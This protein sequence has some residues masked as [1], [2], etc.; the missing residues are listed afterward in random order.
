MWCFICGRTTDGGGALEDR[1]T[2]I[3]VIGSG[4]SGFAAALTAA[5][6]GATVVVFEK[7]SFYG[8]TSRFL[9]GM[10]AVESEM[11]RQRYIGYSRD[12]AFKNLMDYSHWRAD[13]RIVRAFVDESGPTI[14]WLE[15]QGVV[16][17]DATINLLDGLRTYHTIAGGGVMLMKTLAARSKERGVELLLSV[18]VRGIAREVDGTFSITAEKKGVMIR[19]VARA[20]IIA[21][22]GYGSNKEWI[23]RYTGL[24]LGVNLIPIGQFSKMGDGIRI[25][26]ESG[27]GTEG[28]GILLGFRVGPMG[29]GSI[30]GGTL[31]T[32]VVQPH[33]WINPRGERFCNETL[34]FSDPVMGNVAAKLKE[35]YSFTVFDETIKEEMVRNGIERGLGLN[36][37]P[38]TRL[39]D[40]DKDFKAA[41]AKG[42]KNIAVDDSIE[43]LAGQLGIDAV[44]LKATIGEYNGFCEKG[45]DDLFAKD[46]KYLRPLKGPKYYALKAFTVFLGTLGGIRV[47]HLM[48]VVGDDERPVQGLYAA[49]SDAG[50]LYGDTYPM[51]VASGAAAAFAVN[52]GRMAARNALEYVRK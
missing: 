40:F 10:F 23:K 1:E 6:G 29:P 38:G 45:H 33:L 36:S 4:A 14:T 42:N 20:V 28:L 18:P 30:M 49:G 22:G 41:V 37:P 5:Q 52:S 16:F 3:A 31:E 32:A 21:T 11:Q 34:Q 8:G 46:R 26:W 19:A 25:A 2:N 51:T 44:I 48:E 24:D 43:G 12:E 47:N 15:E 27:G 39:V 9:Q 35:G 50:G 7:E 13:P 17:T